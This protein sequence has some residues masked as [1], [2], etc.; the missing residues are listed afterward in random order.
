MSTRLLRSF[1]LETRDT[2]RPANA[3]V[4]LPADH[5]TGIDDQR[6]SGPNVI[7]IG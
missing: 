5:T 3:R 6:L 1:R 7:P 2:R 4:S